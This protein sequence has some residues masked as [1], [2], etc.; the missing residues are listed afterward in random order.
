MTP[1]KIALLP[2]RANAGI[3]LFNP[4]GQVFAGQRFDSLNGAWQMPQGGIDEGESPRDAALR[5]LTEE[6]GVSP[7]LVTIEAETHDWVT[8]DLPVEL[9]GKIWKGRYRGQKQKW[10][11]MRFLGEDAQINIALEHPE[12]SEWKWMEVDE[13]LGKIVPF[14]RDVYAEVFG[15][16]RALLT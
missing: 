6:T 10:F 11:L 16:F 14:K 8:Y 13:L 5:E 7:D 9:V 12:F 2:Y 1:E 15:Q 3:V 4:R